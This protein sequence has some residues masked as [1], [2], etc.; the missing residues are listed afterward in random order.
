V[1]YN[2]HIICFEGAPEIDASRDV[3]VTKVGEMVTLNCSALGYPPSQFTWKPSGKEVCLFAS[4]RLGLNLIF[5]SEK[6][7]SVFSVFCN[8]IHLSV[9]LCV[10]SDSSGE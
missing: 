3:S 9:C 6:N 2:K 4:N 10:V 7:C 8:V 1:T 5:T